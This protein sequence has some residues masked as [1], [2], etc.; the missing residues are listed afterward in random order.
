[1]STIIGETSIFTLED[2]L[3]RQ[4]KL[5]QTLSNSENEITF[6]LKEQT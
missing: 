5:N 3:E 1:M 4:V 2:A 6:L